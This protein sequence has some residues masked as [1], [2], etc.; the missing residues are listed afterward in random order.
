[1]SKGNLNAMTCG[2]TVNEWLE[3]Y[4][5]PLWKKYAQTAEGAGHG[6]MDW[7]SFLTAFIESG[8]AQGTQTPIDVYDS[9]TMSVILPFSGKINQPRAT[10]AAAVSRFYQRQVEGAGRARLR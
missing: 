8:K 5:H 10:C 4:D 9:V 3:K 7:S 6:G 1:M 2:T